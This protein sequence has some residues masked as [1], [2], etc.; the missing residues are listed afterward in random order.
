MGLADLA[1]KYAIEGFT[2][3]EALAAIE[4]VYDSIIDE[5]YIRGAVSKAGLK[6]APAPP[7]VANGKKR[8]K[9]L[10]GA[11]RTVNRVDVCSGVGFCLR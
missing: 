6:F 11:V 8:Y 9:Q 7:R 1:V 2:A 10:S 4:K 5:S 3:K